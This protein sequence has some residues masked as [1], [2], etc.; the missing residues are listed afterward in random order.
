MSC[1]DQPGELAD[2]DRTQLKADAEV[3]PVAA[4]PR[5]KPSGIPYRD[6]T[7]TFCQEIP[8]D[9]ADAGVPPITGGEA[10]TRVVR[11]ERFL[12]SWEAE[13]R[14]GGGYL[15]AGVRASMRP[16]PG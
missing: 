5:Q 16:G 1:R 15:V 12:A 13:C 2:R 7:Q 14:F 4:R 10:V 9:S 11:D 6:L 3:R 8:Y